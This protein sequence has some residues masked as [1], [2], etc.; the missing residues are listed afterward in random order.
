MV[1]SLR[2]LSKKASLPLSIRAGSAKK[3]SSKSV[4]SGSKKK[5][6]KNVSKETKIEKEI[7]KPLES[8]VTAADEDV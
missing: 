6:K 1:S 8:D 4:E 7:E 3:K 5:S 2:M